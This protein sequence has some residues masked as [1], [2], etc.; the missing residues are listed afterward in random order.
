MLAALAVAALPA[1]AFAAW[2]IEPTHTHISFQVGHLGLTK[3]PGIF[4][5]FETQL[6]FDDKDI[7]AASVTIA[8]DT[9]SIDTANDLRDAELR[10][11]TW[12]DARANPRI[13]FVSTSVRHA[14]G[15]HYVISGN[16]TVRGKTLP[17]AFQTTLTARTVNPWLQVPAIGFVG[18]TKIK[19]SDF[20]IA[21]FPAAI[22]DEVDLNIAL[23]LL[24]KP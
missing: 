16:L 20:G 10:G 4:R 24:K 19:R 21:S 15:N 2:E 18:S 3:T 14:E 23:E 1:S 13:T 17:V 9:A 5:K 7:E 12:L 8:I 11:P 22:S 6:N